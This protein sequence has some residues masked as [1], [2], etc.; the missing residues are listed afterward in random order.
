MVT[1][2]GKTCQYQGPEVIRGDKAVIVLNN[3][4]NDRFV[5]M[6][7]DKLDEGKTWQDYVDYV[8]PGTSLDAPPWISEERAGSVEG[9]PDAQEISLRPGMHVIVCARHAGVVNDIPNGVWLSAPFD[10]R[11]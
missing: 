2:D 3:P 10:V 6:H 5:H 8:G 1:F 9:N 11:P 4:T 7:V